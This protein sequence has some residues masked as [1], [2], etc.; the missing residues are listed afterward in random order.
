MDFV[1]DS[2]SIA[3]LEAQVNRRTINCLAFTVLPLTAV[4]VLTLL[5]VFMVDRRLMTL[6]C[7]VADAILLTPWVIC[8]FT[9][10][11]KYWIKY[12]VLFC[13]EIALTF[14]NTLLTFHAVLLFSLPLLC[15]S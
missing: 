7:L 2:H 15:A 9:G 13:V 3:A 8:F 10:T 14:I 4:W 5:G 1:P 6:T 12:M 11:G